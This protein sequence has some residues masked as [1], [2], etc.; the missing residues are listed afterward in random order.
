[1]SSVALQNKDCQK[2]VVS[3]IVN[4]ITKQ[5]SKRKHWNAGDDNV[6]LLALHRVIFENLANCKV[7]T[8]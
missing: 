6:R 7:V 1:M 8:T 5:C 3:A 4:N 2:A